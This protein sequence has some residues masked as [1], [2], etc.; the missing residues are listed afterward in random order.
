MIGW[1]LWRF[2][3]GVIRPPIGEIPK[4]RG[5][6]RA[7]SIRRTGDAVLSLMA[8]WRSMSAIYPLCLGIVFM[9]GTQASLAT[10]GYSYMLQV[11]GSSHSHAA[12]ATSLYWSGIFLGRLIAIPL[13]R[14]YSERGLL[15]TGLGLCLAA[16]GADWLSHVAWVAMAALVVAGY[17]VSG[18]FQLGTSW[19][20]AVAPGRIAIGSS[21][22]MASASFGSLVLPMMTALFSDHFG[23]SVFRWLM[24]AGYLVSAAALAVTP[25]P[26]RRVGAAS[27]IQ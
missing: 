8:G 4:A 9:V 17:G 5:R 18:A 12:M 25:A 10:W 7:P 2:E 11:Y 3:G 20:A 26:N 19:A 6:G 23:F 15:L 22:I 27:L 1:I 21:L 13:S 14:R 16:L 24:L